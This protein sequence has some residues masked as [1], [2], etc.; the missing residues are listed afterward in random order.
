M[1]TPI[2]HTCIEA[3]DNS[4][5]YQ[6]I[7]HGWE[8]I[9]IIRLTSTLFPRSLANRTKNSAVGKILNS[10]LFPSAIISVSTPE[11]FTKFYQFSNLVVSVTIVLGKKSANFALC[12]A[13]GY[14]MIAI[15]HQ[16]RAFKF[17][18]Q[19]TNSSTSYP[20]LVIKNQ[21]VNS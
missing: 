15:K 7:I 8:I 5:P 18:V 16:E 3:I 20:M 12:P 1:R 19:W 10:K 13:E 17:A 4:S 2:I 11:K 6:F 14:E 21:N 9:Q